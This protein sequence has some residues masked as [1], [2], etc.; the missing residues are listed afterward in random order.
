VIATHVENAIGFTGLLRAVMP[1]EQSTDHYLREFS[2]SAGTAQMVW[3]RVQARVAGEAL[4]AQYADPVPPRLE[5]PP[6]AFV[7]SVDGEDVRRTADGGR[8]HEATSS[9]GA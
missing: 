5:E 3:Q 4:T 8:W 7:E 1:V 9:R 6:A 2:L